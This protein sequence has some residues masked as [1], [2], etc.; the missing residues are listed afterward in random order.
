M[1]LVPTSLVTGGAGFLRAHL[2]DAL[3]ARQ[4]LGG[5][6]EVSLDD[7]LRHLRAALSSEAILV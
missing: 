1:P 4:L 7:G 3:P 2:T 6:P 5:Q